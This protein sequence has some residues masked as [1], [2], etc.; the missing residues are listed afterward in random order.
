MARPYVKIDLEKV[1]LLASIGCSAEEIAAELGI[2]SRTVWR[3]CGAIMQ[4]GALKSKVKLRSAI[5]RY[6]LR[7]NVPL[8]M[9]LGK[10]VLGLREHDNE[11]LI[12]NVLTINISNSDAKLI[13][14]DAKPVR[15]VVAGLFE[16]YRPLGNGNGNGNGHDEHQTPA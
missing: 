15:E 11:A 8:L 7:G 2:G 10:A 3:R 4:R 6:A 13:E 16:K 14:A 12:Q 1:E 9:Y 5:Y